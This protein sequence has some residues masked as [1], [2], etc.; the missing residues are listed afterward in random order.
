MRG[1][2]PVLIGILGAVFCVTAGAATVPPEAVFVGAERFGQLKAQA[3]RE[4][5]ER[6][7]IGERTARVGRALVG[8]PYRS[9]TLDIH[10]TR[11]APSV[12]FH[13][14]DCW[15]FF[16]TAL[17]FARLLDHPPAE[18]TRE[19]LLAYLEEDR[20]GNGRCDGTYFSRLHYLE[21]WLED[22]QR[23]GLVVDL[24]RRLGGVRV[25]HATGE[26]TVGWRGYPYLRAHPEAVP[27][28]T[29]MEERIAAQPLYHIPKAAVAAIEPQLRN[30]DIICI[31]SRAPGGFATSHVGLAYRDG[32]GILR[33]LHA[34]SKKSQR[35]VLLDERLSD[36]LAA[37]SG[38]AGIMVAR[39]VR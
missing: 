6:L 24:T 22:N 21:D 32:R 39:P 26:M 38:R 25:P 5:W 1:W 12:N 35:R 19:R 17:A 7:P 34:S 27:R 36:Y 8:T 13:G 10:P 33:F 23:R 9:H 14:L 3:A 28:I 4:R 16:E 11:E 2:Q 20:Y 37:S 15:T 29:A 30:G 31:T 18:R